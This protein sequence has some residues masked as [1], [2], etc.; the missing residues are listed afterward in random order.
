MDWTCLSGT[1]YWCLVRLGSGEFE[2]LSW[3]PWALLLSGAFQ[4]WTAWTSSCCNE[5]SLFGIGNVGLWGPMNY[6]F[7]TSLLVYS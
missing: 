1:S 6:Q 3:Q 5:R 4:S 2:D 7:V